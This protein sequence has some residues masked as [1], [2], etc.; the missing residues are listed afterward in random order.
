MHGSELF[1]VTA[2]A[3]PYGEYCGPSRDSSGALVPLSI[4]EGGEDSQHDAD[5]ICL[6]PS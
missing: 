1:G 2:N 4:T 3:L 5:L 6:H